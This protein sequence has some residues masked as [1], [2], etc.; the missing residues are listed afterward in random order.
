[1]RGGAR[2]KEVEAT[3]LGSSLLLLALVLLKARVLNPKLGPPRE[4]AGAVRNIEGPRPLTT[5]RW[6]EHREVSSDE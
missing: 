4:E 6:K 1:M 5:E 2:G 3:R